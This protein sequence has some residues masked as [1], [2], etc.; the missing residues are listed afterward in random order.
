MAEIA[1]L[2]IIIIIIRYIDNCSANRDNMDDALRGRLNAQLM[3][4]KIIIMV[5]ALAAPPSTEPQ[6]F[7]IIINA[8]MLHT[9][10]SH[11]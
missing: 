1:I 4:K 5:D 9:Q 3:E 7:T 11:V 6:T 10:H 8:Y 2:I